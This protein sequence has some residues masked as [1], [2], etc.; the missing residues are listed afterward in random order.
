MT[1]HADIYRVARIACSK[2]RG[3][4]DY[5]DRLQVAALT[6]W[7]KA[8]AD[9]PLRVHAARQAVI[10]YH[11]TTNKRSDA[12]STSL[13]DEDMPDGWEYPSAED[14]LSGPCVAAERWTGTEARIAAMLA[15]GYRRTE[16]ADHLGVT[17]QRISQITRAMADSATI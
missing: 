2:W 8:D 6:A 5:E 14:T 10:D 7:R 13:S 12:A 4:P 16:I 15:D 1:E 17:R 9:L 3:T 11:R